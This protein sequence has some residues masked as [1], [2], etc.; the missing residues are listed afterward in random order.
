MTKIVQLVV[1]NDERRLTVEAAW[2]RFA[3]AKKKSERTLVLEDGIAAGKAY[4][5]FCELFTR[6]AS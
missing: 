3:D 1:V 5:A 2:Q 6:K 4:A